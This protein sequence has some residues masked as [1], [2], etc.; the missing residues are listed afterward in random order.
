M[1]YTA[2]DK[3]NAPHSMMRNAFV[4]ISV[5][6]LHS[7]RQELIDEIAVAKHTIISHKMEIETIN[8]ELSYR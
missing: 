7:I 1:D 8:W 2:R 3:T 5:E 6:E 4:D